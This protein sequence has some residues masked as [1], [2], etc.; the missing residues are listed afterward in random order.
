ML[1][2]AFSCERG[3]GSEQEVGLRTL[4]AAASCHDVW[5][6]TWDG[7]VAG[8]REL[9]AGHPSAPRIHIEA[10]PLTT[11]FRRLGFFSYHWYYDRWQREVARRAAELHRRVGF[12]VVH[13]VT[14]ATVWTRVG[15]AAVPR[16]L[17]WGPVGGGVEAPLSLL[18]ELGVKGLAENAA[19]VVGRRVL[20]SLPYTGAPRTRH[21]YALAQN[22]VTA[23]RMG[24]R[25]ARPVLSNATSV[26]VAHVRPSGARDRTIMV[27][28]RLVAW[29][30]T[31]LALRALRELQARDAVMHFY[32]TGPDRLRIESTARRW[33]LADRVRLHGWTPRDVL[34]ERLATAGALLFPS[35]HDEAG[36]CVAEALSFSTP[37]VCLDH[38][39]PPE[40]VSRW[41]TSPARLVAPSSPRVTA[42]RL[43]DAIDRFLTDPPPVCDVPLLPDTSY[44]KRVLETY[45]RA[46]DEAAGTQ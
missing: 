19:R 1:M 22:R 4:L 38:G 43:A 16:P 15:V 26:D 37:V 40:V 2:S 13:H 17:V 3:K 6:L 28:G 33:G 20:R 23:I 7:G 5:L 12:D 41:P 36:M 25:D 42:R 14:H 44:A 27:V 21:V 29:K 45:E 18:T 46:V 24:A 34:L 32:G 39:G 9:L 10:I 8:L 30:G 35:L 31:R 11:E